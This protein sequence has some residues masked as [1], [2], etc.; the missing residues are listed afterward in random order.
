[1]DV[2]N[3][4]IKVTSDSVRY[5]SLIEGVKNGNWSTVLNLPCVISSVCTTGACSK[6]QKRKTQNL[7]I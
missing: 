3:V 1:M 6:R 7:M 4:F 5:R 2:S